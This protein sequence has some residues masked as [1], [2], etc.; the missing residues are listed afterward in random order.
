V[1]CVAV[2]DAIEIEAPQDW[3]EKLRRLGLT[4]VVDPMIFRTADVFLRGV[5]GAGQDAA[6]VWKA[7]SANVGSFSAFIDS[8]VLE[9]RIPIF[10]YL[11]SFPEWDPAVDTTH[12]SLIDFCNA[13]D[14]V[15]V[16]VTVGYA[17]YWEMKEAALAELAEH[18]GVPRDT[19]AEIV[20]ELSG[21]D[22]EWR[23]D[24]GQHGQ[25]S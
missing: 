3:E 15:L 19:A 16:P 20:D 12:T 23:P 5:G 25:G 10:D 7:I 1:R 24:L 22:Y 6:G 21:F 2:G 18:P 4:L 14:E 17:A 11:S 13:E 8:I 9:E